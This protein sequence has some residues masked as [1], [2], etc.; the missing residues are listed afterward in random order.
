M[1]RGPLE[2]M[3][4]GGLHTTCNPE[5]GVRAAVLR[6]QVGKEG[7]PEEKG[8]HQLGWAGCLD[9]LLCSLPLP[10]KGTRSTCHPSEEEKEREA[11]E[12]L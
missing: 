2:D 4:R 5:L 7:K 3:G 12:P 6:K 1:R 11:R 10:S 8:G 9:P